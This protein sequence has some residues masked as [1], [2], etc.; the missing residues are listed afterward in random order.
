[1]VETRDLWQRPPMGR[2]SRICRRHRPLR[3]KFHLFELAS[4]EAVLTSVVG[5]FRDGDRPRGSNTGGWASVC[6]VHRNDAER[7]PKLSS[8][9][10]GVV[11]A[12]AKA[13]Q[14]STSLTRSSPPDVAP[15]TW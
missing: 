14:R 1:V 4:T 12:R 9:R 5:E 7:I 3:A 15:E 6:V 10:S 8:G 13:L 11:A 2:D